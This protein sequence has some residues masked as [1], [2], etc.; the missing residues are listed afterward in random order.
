[1]AASFTQFGL[2]SQLAFLT[3]GPVADLKLA[4]LYGATFRRVFLLRL[5]I[6]AAPVILVG[7]LLFEAVQ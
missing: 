2:G 5:V 1:V 4:A 7:S 3:F 6:V